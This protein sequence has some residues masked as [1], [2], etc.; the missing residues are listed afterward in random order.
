MLETIDL[1]SRVAVYQQ[2]ENH[3]QFAIASG[4]LKDGERLPSVRVMSEK[5]DVNPNTVAKAYRDLEVMGLLFTRRGLGVF[6]GDGAS[7][8]CKVDCTTK[9]ISRFHEVVAEAEAAGMNKQKLTKTLNAS[10][11]LNVNPYSETP[12]SVLAIA[13][14]K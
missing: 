3:L 9:I 6:V 7:A 13:K 14:E 1:R 8:K 2:I 4:E 11:G 5:L 10:F 12:K